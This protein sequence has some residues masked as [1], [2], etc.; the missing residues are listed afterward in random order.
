MATVLLMIS[1]N[2]MTVMA[3]YSQEKRG[4]RDD[5]ERFKI[6]YLSLKVVLI[7]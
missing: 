5:S 7:S 6:I 2:E 1:S 3:K 4:R